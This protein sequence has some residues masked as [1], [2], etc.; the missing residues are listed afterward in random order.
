MFPTSRNDPY[1][2][3]YAGSTEKLSPLA[4]KDASYNGLVS[5]I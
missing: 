1:F 3:R 4:T 2:R 5:Q